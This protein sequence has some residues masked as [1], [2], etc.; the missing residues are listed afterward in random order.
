MEKKEKTIYDLGLHETLS[1]EE[2]IPNK[3]KSI[4]DSTKNYEVTKVPGGWVYSFEY[5]G[6]RQIE[7]VFVPFVNQNIKITGTVPPLKD[8]NFKTEIK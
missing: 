5:P 8:K 2:K 7:T 6:F 4:R 1:I 3:D